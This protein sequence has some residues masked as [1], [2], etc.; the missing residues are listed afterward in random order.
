MRFI[1]SREMN[2]QKK[3]LRT[4][5]CFIKTNKQNM[6]LNVTPTRLHLPLCIG[7]RRSDESQRFTNRSMKWSVSQE[8]KFIELHCFVMSKGPFNHHGGSFIIRSTSI[9]LYS[10]NFYFSDIVCKSNA[11]IQ[12]HSWTHLALAIGMKDY[13]VYLN[14]K[15]IC[16]NSTVTLERSTVSTSS[17][18]RVVFRG[19]NFNGVML[20]FL[21]LRFSAS[22]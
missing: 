22:M 13:M 5:R 9:L 3:R 7:L 2:K 12:L 21:H 1:E 17:D 16:S 19:G 10:A 14:G 11:S 4:I 6:S 15:E 18:D 8:T 20:Y